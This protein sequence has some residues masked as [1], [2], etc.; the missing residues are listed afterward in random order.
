[1]PHTWDPERYLTYADERGRP[2]VEL[3]A[4]V[5]AESPQ[6]VVDLGCGP[7]NLTALLRERWPHAALRGLDSSP[8][9]IA[10]GAGRRPV[11]RLRGRRP[12]RLG[13]GRAARGRPGLERHSPVGARPPRPPPGARRPGQRRRL[14]CLPGAWQLRRAQPHDPD[15]AGRPAAV[16]RP[17]PGR[18]RPEQ[19]RPGDVPR[20]ARRP[21]LHAST[22][23][24]RRTCTSSPAPTRSS[25]G[26]PAPA[27]GR[28]SRRCPTTCGGVRGRVPAA[29]ARGVPR[30]RRPRRPSVPPDLRGRAGRP[31]DRAPPRPGRV[32]AGRGGRRPHA[33][34]PTGSG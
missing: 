16:R 26:S 31:H 5:G 9:M 13:A 17:H 10:P 11:D 28:L 21:R 19:P 2:F 30:A 20:G 23:G 18:R 14:A 29:P 12:P 34:T 6:T 7:G 22:R 3:V 15:R 24:R 32:P 27:P 4:R 25:P 1:M 33:S 8:E